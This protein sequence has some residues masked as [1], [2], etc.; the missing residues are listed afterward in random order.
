MVLQALWVQWEMKG[1]VDHVE[2]LVV[3]GL[4]DHQERQ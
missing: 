1:S 2:M 4:Q 3:L